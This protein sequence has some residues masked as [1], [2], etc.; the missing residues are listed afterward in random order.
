VRKNAKDPTVKPTPSQFQ[1][2]G[3]YLVATP[4]G[5]LQDITLRALDILKLADLIVCE[6]TRVTGVLLSHYGISKPT[7]SYNDHN[8]E[9][10]RPKI[11]RALAEGKRVALVS[12]AGTP[13]ISD[14]GYKLVREAQAGRY[15]ITTIPGAS[16]VLAGLLLSGLPTDRF[17]FAGF[18]PPKKEAARKAI[19]E[20]AAIPSTLVLFEAARRLPDT[21]MLLAEELG[22]R[23][24]AVT[25]ELT[26]RFEESHRG[27]LSGLAI[28]YDKEGA[29][30]GEVVVVIAPP[31][32]QVVDI[33][34]ET[35][36]KKLLGKHGVKEASNMLAEKTGLPRK[37]LYALALKVKD[38]ADE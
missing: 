29:P 23:E 31:G 7:L 16:S 13:L 37:E 5:N 24:A 28:H 26:K 15:Y 35:E 32:K 12:D 19:K 14:P 20:L 3:L 2:P 18:L 30:K 33:D 9:E 11:L 38:D 10:R 27:A 1:P 36:L 34:L 8:G 21:L 17:F 6:D 25:R 4:I 22:D